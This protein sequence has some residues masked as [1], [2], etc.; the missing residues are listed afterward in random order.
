MA[1]LSDILPYL[2]VEPLEAHLFR[3]Q[4]DA[5][6]PHVFGGQVLAQAISAAYHT[7]AEDRALHSLH[8]YF[9][10]AGDWN[11]PIVY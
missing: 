9:I 3:G 10:R 2:D 6:T 11:R 7:V 4:N 1:Q 5:S 8:S